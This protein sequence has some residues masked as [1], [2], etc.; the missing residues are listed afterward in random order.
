MH[1][2]AL[3]LVLLSALSTTHA[4]KC[5]VDDESSIQDTRDCCR[6]VQGSFA[7]GDDC[8]D[9]TILTKLEEFD[10]LGNK[11]SNHDTKS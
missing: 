5:L 6:K 7:Y 1:F 10:Q 3:V 9:S 8:T 11:P 2:P 4:C